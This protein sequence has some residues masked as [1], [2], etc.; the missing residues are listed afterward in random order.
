LL[1]HADSN[2]PLLVAGLKE[3]FF[4]KAEIATTINGYPWQTPIRF[5]E[6]AE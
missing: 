3:T 4:V 1:L 6:S 2:Q 5:V